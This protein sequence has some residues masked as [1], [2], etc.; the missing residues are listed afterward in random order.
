MVFSRC[1]RSSPISCVLFGFL[2]V[3]VVWFARAMYSFLRVLGQYI[4]G[5]CRKHLF[6]NVCSLLD[7]AFVVLHVSAP[8]SKTEFSLHLCLG[9]RQEDY[10]ICK[11]SRLGLKSKTDVSDPLPPKKTTRSPTKQQQMSCINEGRFP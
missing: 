7:V 5:M 4:S 6:M 8:Y 9:G 3:L 2:F 11:I 10:V 1:A